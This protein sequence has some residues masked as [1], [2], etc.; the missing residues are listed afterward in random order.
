[1]DLQHC[2]KAGVDAY[3]PSPPNV[4]EQRSEVQEYPGLHSKFE[5][6]LGYRPPLK[7]PTN[8]KEI[9]TT[10]SRELGSRV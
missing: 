1:L 2:I 8:Q 3:N 7:K 9:K 4:E 10:P 6:S 5:V